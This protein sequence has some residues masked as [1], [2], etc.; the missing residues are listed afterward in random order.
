MP[1]EK[2]L[3]GKTPEG[4]E[5]SVYTLTNRGGLRVKLIDFG[6]LVTELHI[7]DRD[8]KFADVVL[9]FDKLEDYLA[10]PAY[11]GCTTGRVANRIAG[12]KFTLDG[13]EYTL[14]VND[15]PHHLHGGTKGLNKRVW[16]SRAI[17][18]SS[19]SAVE[20][21]YVSPDAEEGYPGELSIR[22]TYTL[23]NRDE[24]RI[25]YEAVSDQA[26]PVNL[27]NHSYFNLAGAGNGTI[28]D[29]QLILVADRYTPVD[30]TGIPTGRIVPAAGSVMEFRSPVTVGARIGELRGD[31]G[32]Y[33]HNY[34]L[35][36]EGDSPS[37][38]A[39][40]RDPGSG[41]V[42]E[43]YTTEPGIQLYTGNYL[44][45]SIRGKGGVS[46]PKHAALCLE[47]QHF[48]D[49]VNQPGFPSTILRPGET[50]RS[51]TVHKFLTD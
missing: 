8:G 2:E 44:D 28:L 34:V 5:I 49:S 9:G 13:K 39:R 50:Y 33:D 42:L 1:I 20:F 46:Y 17:P 21:T 15:R 23:T 10:N 45:G 24:L 36:N 32:G 43:I 6:A 14:A 41:R 11:F 19:D 4:E 29:H 30:S 40:V 25:D 27:T 18:S 16:K 48:P 35:N 3:Y 37:L 51:T 26:T 47:T 22:V 31:P 12:G 38:A 7:P